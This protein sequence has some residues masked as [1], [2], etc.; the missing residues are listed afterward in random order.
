MT[1]NE[2][3]PEQTLGRQ[4]WFRETAGTG[5]AVWRPCRRVCRRSHTATGARSQ[6]GAALFTTGG[7]GAVPPHRDAGD[8]AAGPCGV[9]A[10]ACAGRPL[11]RT[12]LVAGVT[13]R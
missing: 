10:R 13:A 7:L 6:D 5:C 2:K 9:V 11:L 3:I 8:L 12:D 1:I 4:G